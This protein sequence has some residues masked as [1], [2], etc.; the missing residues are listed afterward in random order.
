MKK[1]VVLLLALLALLIAAAAGG[2]CGRSVK[3][4]FNGQ[5]AT[6][7][8]ITLHVGEEFTVDLTVT[9]DEES[10]AFAELDEPGDT[11]AYDWR[12]GDE[13]A[14]AAGKPCN[15]SSPARFRWTL[16]PSGRWVDGTAPVNIYFQVNRRGGNELTAS[17]YFT[18][19]DAYIAPGEPAAAATAKE[20]AT[21]TPG[22]GALAALSGLLGA[23]FTRRR[24][25]TLCPLCPP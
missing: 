14:P 21:Q 7:S 1:R 2:A 17:G 25:L 15:A 19:V 4:Y 11:R 9:P 6:V 10:I 16:A 22:P 3:A 8:G 20:K 13:L 5:E 24:K 23:A 18:V 12:G